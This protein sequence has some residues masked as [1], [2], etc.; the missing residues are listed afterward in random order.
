MSDDGTRLVRFVVQAGFSPE[1]H[2]TIAAGH[3]E[4]GDLRPGEA[5]EWVRGD[6]SRITRCIGV[7]VVREDPPREPPLTGVLV[8]GM[9]PEDLASGDVL[10]TPVGAAAT[11]EGGP[12]RP[13]GPG[14]HGVT[15][16]VDGPE[17]N[18]FEAVGARPF[19][20]RLVDRFYVGV[21]ADPVI[22]PLY[23]DDLTESIAHTA[24]GHLAA[25][26]SSQRWGSGPEQVWA[27]LR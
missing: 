18:V 26:T 8:E 3:L 7:A 5:L 6:A 4:S 25:H 23:P 20:D 15:M 19:F 13:G 9:A 16:A 2:G 10:R 21:A 24:V 17:V 27:W 14:G 11:T 1:G 22:R 12:S